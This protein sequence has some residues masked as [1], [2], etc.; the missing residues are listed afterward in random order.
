MPLGVAF[1]LVAYGLYSCC[2]AIIKGF[3]AGHMSVHEIAFFSALFSMIPAIFTKPPHERW[4]NVLR[5]KHPWLVHLRGMSGLLGNICIIYAFVTVPLAE[6]Y[7][8]AFLAP[9][10]IVALSI[11]IL[12]ETVGWSRIVLLTGSFIGV[13]LVVR[14]GF[15]E[16]HL[17]HLTAIAAA[18]FGAVTTTVLRYVAPVEQ[19]ISLITIALGYIVVVNG[20]WMIPTYV[21]PTWQEFVLLLTI[22]AL[23][24]TGNIVFIAAT[25]TAPASQIAPAQYSQIFWAIALGAIFFHEIPDAIAY[26]GLAIVVGTG[27][28][29][30]IS[31]DTRIRIFSRPV[32][33][34]AGPATAIA[35][36]SPPPS[37]D[38]ATT[39]PVVGETK[40]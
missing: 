29:N 9:I 10:F 22:G 33:T 40:A 34:G 18:A 2:D 15:R 32:Q 19:R 12:K 26:V 7:S 38:E 30:V 37:A 31:V 36:V 3:G 14:P 28:L 1:S 35:G 39:S 21:M 27:I 25:R 24:G 6:A 8:L 23:G 11:F 16:I 5:L 17:G 4:R 13:L 20:I